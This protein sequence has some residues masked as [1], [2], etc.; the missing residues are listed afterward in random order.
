MNPAIRQRVIYVLTCSVIL[1]LCFLSVWKYG[2][3][4]EAEGQRFARLQ[5]G[6]VRGSVIGMEARLGGTI[7]DL[8]QLNSLPVVQFVEQPFLTDRFKTVLER[9]KAGAVLEVLRISPDGRVLHRLGRSA[10]ALEVKDLISQEEIRGWSSAARRGRVLAGPIHVLADGSTVFS[11]SIPAYEETTNPAHRGVTDRYAGGTVY[12][13]KFDEIARGYLDASEQLTPRSYACVYGPDGRFVMHGKNSSLAGKSIQTGLA[14]EFAGRR[15]VYHDA[16]DESEGTRVAEV[17][18]RDGTSRMARQVA[19]WGT[20]RSAG[21]NWVVMLHSPY[22]AVTDAARSAFAW[23]FGVM[24]ILAGVVAAAG[25]SLLRGERLH[26]R[27]REETARRIGEERY[28]RLV[29]QAADGIFV[30]EGEGRIVEVNPAG[31]ELVGYTKDDL[32]GKSLRDFFAYGKIRKQ[33]LP[34]PQLGS[35]DRSIIE[36]VLLRI[37][38]EKIHT[39]FSIRPIDG[40]QHQVIV[41]DLTARRH[42]EEEL[43]KA[44][45]KY[46]SLV[47]RVPAVTY[48]ASLDEGRTTM[49]ISPQVEPILGF[50]MTDWMRQPD[51]WRRRL[52]EEDRDRVLAEYREA[53]K[54]GGSFRSEYRMMT[55]DDRAVWIRDE[56]V[57]VRDEAGEALLMQGFMRDVTE[58]KRAEE[59]LKASQGQYDLL[60]RSHPEPMVLFER[61]TRKL[62]DVNEAAVREYG[63]SREEFLSMSLDDMRPPEEQAQLDA[64]ARRVAGLERSAEAGERLISRHRRKDGSIRITEVI[65]TRVTFQGRPAVIAWLRTH[66]G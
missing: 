1:A 22:G 54:G 50:P 63:Y 40:L 45:A 44:E 55:R 13:L 28:R 52:H 34:L 38:G 5:A 39:E 61:G 33:P 29:E 3:I 21:T 15:F 12:V 27:L 8:E 4:L 32:I 59:S 17:P 42:S 7:A 9:D 6:L 58:R 60:F 57:I 36:R 20:V 18:V 25:L 26:A 19:S 48:S 11:L 41:R 43:R 10:E 46:R 16:L 62:L 56:G 65:W 66:R 14:E 51:L 2:D 35:A 24:F 53:V 30:L 49:Y 37:D 47:E 23:T 64:Y 31:C